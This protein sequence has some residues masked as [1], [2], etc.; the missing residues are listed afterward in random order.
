MGEAI[1]LAHW[2]C[3]C[4]ARMA[5]GCI[6]DPPLSFDEPARNRAEFARRSVV[7]CTRGHET[8]EMRGWHVSTDCADSYDAH[9]IE[10]TYQG[11]VDTVSTVIDGEGVRSLIPARRERWMAGRLGALP[12]RL[13]A[14]RRYRR[15]LRTGRFDFET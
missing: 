8:V 13:S 9:P 5:S 2:R 1:E 6:Q 15:W 10:L 12:R 4:G 11:V 7:T 14:R 3:P